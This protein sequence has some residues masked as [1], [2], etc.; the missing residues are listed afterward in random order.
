MPPSLWW[1]ANWIW[2]ITILAAIGVLA[3]LITYRRRDRR[4]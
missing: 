2:V 3:W 1:T 4:H